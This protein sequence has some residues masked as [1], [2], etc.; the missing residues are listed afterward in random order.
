M[1]ARKLLE[2]IPRSI[3]VLRRLTV[4]A[5]N[6][7]LTLHQTRVLYLIKEGLGQSQIAD[8]LQVSAAAVCKL[9]HQ[10]SEKGFITMSPGKDRRERELMLTKEGSRVLA[11]V[12]K[13]LEKRIHKGLEALSETEA[14]DLEKG[15]VVLDKLMSQI[16]EG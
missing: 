1:P 9:M 10:L 12:N 13:Q 11:A 4:S 14:R 6:G 16:K 15:L 8:S 7:S 2:S 5:L 3:R